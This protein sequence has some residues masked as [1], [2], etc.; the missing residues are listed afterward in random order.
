MN[1]SILSANDASALAVKVLGLD[2][3]LIDLTSNEGLAASL[4]RAASFL[5]PTSPGRLIDAVQGAV[6]PVSPNGSLDRDRLIEILDLLVGAGDLLELRQEE[7]RA[8]R[9]LYLGP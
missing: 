2:Q 6:G 9:L 1:L 7:E 8:T 3:E 4:R 5:C